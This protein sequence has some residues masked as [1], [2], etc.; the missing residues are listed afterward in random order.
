MTFLGLSYI[1][2]I[3]GVSYNIDREGLWVGWE[4][5]S[6]VGLASGDS[7]PGWLLTGCRS[8]SLGD[9]ERVRGRLAWKVV[10]ASC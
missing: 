1:V 8:G 3:E 9:H 6:V 5:G 4:R 7:H 2:G 10:R